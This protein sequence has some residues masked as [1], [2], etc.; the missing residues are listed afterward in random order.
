[1]GAGNSWAAV[2]INEVMYDPDGIDTGK[3]WIEIHSNGTG[4]TDITGYQLNATSGD[5]YTFGSFVLRG[6]SYALIHWNAGGTNSDVHL[7]TGT[8]TFGNMGNTSGYVALFRSSVHNSETICDYVEY[9]SGSHTWESTAVA[10]KIWSTGDFAPDVA[11][12]HSLEF[13]GAGDGGSFWK[14]SIAQGGSPLLANSVALGG[15]SGHV[16]LQSVITDQSTLITFEI[17]MPETTE[18][19]I[20]GGNDEDSTKA[21]TQVTTGT[22][23]SYMLTDI[24]AGTYDMTVKGNKWLREKVTDVGVAGGNSAIVDFPILKGGDANDSN[25]VNVLDLNIL[26]STYGKSD[27]QPGYDPQADFNNSNSVNVLD[28]NILKTNYGRK[29]V[30]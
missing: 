16:L 12:G 22:D 13:T 4:D 10:A 7:Y 2:I 25:S 29:G 3:E 17:R 21:G 19:M 23:G 8:G 15:I 20:D 27:N 1:M 6:H 28:L 24:P 26:K 14:S 18:I 9:G 11:E 5:Y 30:P